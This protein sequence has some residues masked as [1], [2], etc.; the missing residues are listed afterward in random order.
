MLPVGKKQA[1]AKLSVAVQL[2]H[3]RGHLQV[4]LHVE[5]VH[6]VGAVEPHEEHV[7]PSLDGDL[8]FAHHQPLLLFMD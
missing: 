1:T 5:G 4:H 2:A 3:C 8:L 6:L 7:T